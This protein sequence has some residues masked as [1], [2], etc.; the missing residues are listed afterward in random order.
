[1]PS[2]GGNLNYVIGIVTEVIYTNFKNPLALFC[3]CDVFIKETNI[4]GLEEKIRVILNTTP[5]EKLNTEYK[6]FGCVELSKKY[7]KSFKCDTYI[8][9]IPI[10]TVNVI[11][12]LSSGLFKGI[13]R[14]RAE[15]I[16]ETLGEDC[17]IQIVNTP[18]ILRTVKGIPE[19]TIS[20]I[21]ET[22]IENLEM[23][24]IITKLH[25]WNIS[26]NKA[27]RI[28][29]I[30]GDA[31]V[32]RIIE[33]PYCLANSIEGIGFKKSDE[34]ADK[35]DINGTDNRRI[36][37]AIEY[38]LHEIYEHDGSTFATKGYITQKVVDILYRQDGYYYS[39]EL[40]IE[41]L[42]ELANT[43][44][45]KIENF[46]SEIGQI[47]Q[48]E[49]RIFL[50]KYYGYEQ[51]IAKK[52]TLLHARKEKLTNQ[53]KNKLVDHIIDLSKILS[54]ELSFE[55]QLAIL[56]SMCNNVLII[57]GGP[58]TGKSTII[59]LILMLYYK[60][61]YYD[62]P[63]A[64]LDKVNLLA[65]TGSAAKR[66]KEITEITAKTIHHFVYNDESEENETDRLFIIDEMSMMDISTMAQF[67]ERVHRGDRLILVGD[68][69]QLPPVSAGNVFKDIIESNAFPTIEL[70]TVFRQKLHSTIQDL[71]TCIRNEEISDKLL[72]SSDNVKYVPV[73]KVDIVE[74]IK[75]EMFYALDQN[76]P[77][78]DIQIIAPIHLGEQGITL[79]NEVIQHLFRK[80]QIVPTYGQ[81]GDYS[82]I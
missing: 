64:F 77:F 5:P 1:M 38:A 65:P 71:A 16:V 51:K 50:A 72:K 30:Y 46:T 35:L 58:G 57:T 41:N 36:K 67:L 63:Y 81:D 31:S 7:G 44:V 19:K 40:I 20:N 13:K 73:A 21:Q 25:E 32:Q 43:D 56:E 79:I 29:K 61:F 55:Q 34:I 33:N 10:D 4:P 62:N 80:R 15:Y 24:S 8:R 28:F 59:K 47:R 66:M 82:K 78:E 60:Y 22:I 68:K 17:L 26:L 45:L 48:M 39:S 3:V 42:T 49:E 23:Q 11:E 53:E 37:G 14:K 76:I 27:K 75:S 2:T 54:F 69:E 74:T 6:F 9:S 12:F 18:E 52:L 70:K